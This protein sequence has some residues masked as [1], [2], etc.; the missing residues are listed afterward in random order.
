MRGGFV[1]RLT[2]VDSPPQILAWAVFFGYAQQVFTR[3]VD[4][5]ANTV[6]EGVTVEVPEEAASHNTASARRR[7]GRGKPGSGAPTADSSG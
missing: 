3:L 7:R 1:P 4:K 5:Q 6:L 2:A